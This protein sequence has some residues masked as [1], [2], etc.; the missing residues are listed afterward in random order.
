VEN[1]NFLVYKLQYHQGSD[2]QNAL[3][4]VA[5][6][7]PKNDPNSA[8]T[9]LADAISSLQWI[10]VTNSLLGTGNQDVLVKLRE[11]IQSLDAPLRQVFI[12]VLVI[13]TS[14]LNTLN[15]G[16]QWGSQIQFLNKANI[17]FG[18]FP[19]ANSPPTTP[20]L[21]TPLS[22]INAT[23]TPKGGNAAQSV[24]FVSGFDLGVIG[25]IIMNKGKS[26]ISLGSLVNALQSD[27]DTTIVM[28]PKI[29]A[30]DNNQSTI[31]VGQNIPFTGSVVTNT[32]GTSSVLTSANVEYRDVGVSL[33]I[34]P[35]LGN[36]DLITLDVVNDISEQT[37]GTTTLSGSV[38][39][40]QTTHTHM[41]TRILVPN[42]HFV[43]LSGM[44][45][46]SRT[47]FR[48]GLP[49]LGGLPVI[50]AA[51][52]E[53]DRTHNA[54]NVIIFMR[55]QIIDTAAQYKALTEH[56]EWLYKDEAAKSFMKEEFDHGIDMIKI[57]ENE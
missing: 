6:S 54:N 55:P 45:N 24:P 57:P 18:N 3:K 13:E 53:N 4:Q 16:L 20:N 8:Q 1:A 12:E 47:H 36:D 31:F 32:S 25:D 23:T 7:M 56:Q 39:G 26:F 38:T 43:V 14:M 2:I 48:T 29:I 15:F 44:I 11:L 22:L 30:Q 17:G 5:A 51:F 40:L 19:I 33:T 10:Q 37:A 27:S 9:A 41:E 35:T 50:G 52:S 42:N 21:S 28:N 49:C 46:D 34:T